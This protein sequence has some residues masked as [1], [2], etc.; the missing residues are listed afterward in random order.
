MIDSSLEYI[1][2]QLNNALTDNMT[3]NYISWKM[4]SVKNREE[5]KL[6]ILMKRRYLYSQT[7]YGE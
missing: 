1:N 3:P 7:L 4:R 6:Q 5:I 2:L